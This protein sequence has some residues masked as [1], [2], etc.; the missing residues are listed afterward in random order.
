MELSVYKGTDVLFSVKVTK[1]DIPNK[2]IQIQHL[3]NNLVVLVGTPRWNDLNT[4]DMSAGNLDV[5]EF[6][7][8]TYAHQIWE[9]IDED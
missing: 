5:L 6:K 1:F 8:Y 2:C 7:D 3:E 4:V 9:H